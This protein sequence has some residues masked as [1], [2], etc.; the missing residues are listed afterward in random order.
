MTSRNDL[1]LEQKIN[2][3]RESE[4][5]LSYRELKDKFQISIGAVSNILKRKN[6]Y[7]NDYE[8]NHNKKLKR[9]MKNDLS[10]KINDN[11]YDWF[12]AQRSKRIP[13]SGP[14]LQE[15]ARKIATELGDTTGFKASNGWLDRFRSRYNVQFRTTSGEAAAVDSN[16]IEDWKSRLPVILEQ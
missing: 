11:V 5:G 2:L 14:V 15:Y 10:Q 13:I 3:I 12:V 4:H 7:V 8:C 6:E 16:T 1:N 9:K